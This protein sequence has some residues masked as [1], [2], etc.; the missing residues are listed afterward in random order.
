MTQ[1]AGMRALLERRTAL[2]DQLQTIHSAHPDALPDTAQSAWDTA[3]AEL[4]AVEQRIT[5]QSVLDDTEKRVRGNPIAGGDT[6]WREM[7][8]GYS[9]ARAILYNDSSVDTGREREASQEVSKRTGRS[10]RGIMVPDE[11]FLERRAGQEA[12]TGTLGGFLVPDVLRP[13]LYIDRLRAASI[14]PRLNVTYLDGLIGSTVIPRL[15]GSG[16]VVWIAENEEPT[17]SEAG[18]GSVTLTPRTAACTMSYSRRMLLNAVPSIEQ[19]LRNDIARQ[20]ATALDAAAIAGPGGKQPIGLLNAGV[21]VVPIDTNGGAPTVE[22]LIDLSAAPGERDA[23]AA[24]PSWLTNPKVVAT[25]QKIKESGTGR[26]IFIDSL[27]GSLLGYGLVSSTTVPSD[28]TKGTSS[29]VCSAAI[30]GSWSSMLI[31]RWSGLDILADPYSRG[32]SGAVRLYAFQDVD[33]GF[34]HIES[35]AA[36]KDV[37]TS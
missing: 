20:V 31:G 9:L 3:T 24:G 7:L 26:Y 25:V 12:A 4:Q 8:A 29:G 6:R 19:L 13:D 10:P 23:T 37:V 35:F 1:P 30:F 33:V 36:F 27:P 5:R 15:T 17:E 22:D 14:L 16:S 2:K 11:I 34:R 28:L 32:A 21:P 18:F